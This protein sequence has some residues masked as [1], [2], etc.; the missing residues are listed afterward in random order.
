MHKLM[1]F[2]LTSIIFHEMQKDFSSRFVVVMSVSDCVGGLVELGS[3]SGLS[4]MRSHEWFVSP[5]RDQPVN[6]R[7]TNQAHKPL[8][9]V[10][11]LNI[12]CR[13]GLWN[14]TNN[15]DRKYFIFASY[16]LEFNLE[17]LWLDKSD[18][19]TFTRD[20]ENQTLPLLWN[21]LEDEG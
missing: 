2:K 10:T 5:V 8:R 15:T 14:H 4:S 9:N 21:L 12:D 17:S 1:V 3:G 19:Q 13:I 18:Y 7:Q 20:E 16:Q 6:S 11:C